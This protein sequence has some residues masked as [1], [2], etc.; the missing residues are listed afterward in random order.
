MILLKRSLLTNYHPTVCQPK[1]KTTAELWLERCC[2]C[3]WFPQ[4]VLA[5]LNM[6]MSPDE[7]KTSNY[8][9]LKETWN[10][11][12][13]HMWSKIWNIKNNSKNMIHRAWMKLR[14]HR[15]I[16]KLLI[17][18]TSQIFLGRLTQFGVPLIRTDFSNTPQA[19]SANNPSINKGQKTHISPLLVHLLHIPYILFFL[20]PTYCTAIFLCLSVTFHFTSRV[21]SFYSLTKA[22]FH[23]FSAENTDI[24]IYSS[25]IYKMC[26][27]FAV[28]INKIGVS[29]TSEVPFSHLQVL[30]IL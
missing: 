19:C 29:N 26:V 11:N 17:I 13:N 12:Y 4:L 3:N 22:P 15:N 24:D 5:N 20:N 7:P 30:K 2:W 25:A 23:S 14:I 28:F 6:V 9:H 18:A 27:C 1:F 10:K 8:F 16:Q 21:V